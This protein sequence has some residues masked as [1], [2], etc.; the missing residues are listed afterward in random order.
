MTGRPWIKQPT[1][2]LDDSRLALVSDAAQR[3]Y[4]MLYLLAGRL[5]AEGLFIENKRQLSNDELAFK[6]RVD[7]SRM[8]SSIKELQKANLLHVN[9]KGPMIADW[10]HE[11][12][13]W[14]DK[15][16]ND[17]ERQQR[18]RSVTRDS[19]SVT[20]DGEAVTPLDKI[21]KK[22]RSRGEGGGVINESVKS[23]GA[24]QKTKRPPRRSKT[25]PAGYQGIREAVNNGK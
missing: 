15:R 17:R 21:K 8:R 4:F 22:N 25:E 14:R 19:E 6:I 2:R 10:K 24:A 1:T 9:G 11:Q 5:D 12:I 16:E 18:H 20:R 3:D 13:N 7:P 23:R